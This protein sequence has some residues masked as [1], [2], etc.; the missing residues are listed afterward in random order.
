MSRR[1]DGSEVHAP[2]AHRGSP[3]DSAR[4]VRDLRFGCPRGADRPVAPPLPPPSCAPCSS[5]SGRAP[6]APASPRRRRPAAPGQILRWRPPRELTARLGVGL[7]HDER[8]VGA[9]QAVEPEVPP[10]GRQPPELDAVL[11]AA[12]LLAS[13]SAIAVVEPRLARSFAEQ[14]GGRRPLSELRAVAGEHGLEHPAPR[15]QSRARRTPRRRCR[16]PR[17]RRAGS[18]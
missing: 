12:A 13:A 3:P 9:R 16:R 1:R 4:R 15:A 7:Q 8:G 6:R 2:P 10:L 18:S 11:L 17:A 14:G 5:A